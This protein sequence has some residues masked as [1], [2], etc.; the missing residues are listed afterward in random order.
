[1]KYP[2]VWFSFDDDTPG[3]ASAGGGVN[4]SDGNTEVKRI[5]VTQRQESGEGEKEENLDEVTPNSVMYGDIKRAAIKVSIF[6]NIWSMYIDLF[7]SQVHD[8]IDLHFYTPEPDAEPIHVQ[9]GVTTAE[10][11]T[12]DLGP[13]VLTHYKGIT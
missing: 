5:V 11:L 2:G 3:A 7:P 10:D 9:I 6:G 4:A 12:C 13:P 1:M 8:G